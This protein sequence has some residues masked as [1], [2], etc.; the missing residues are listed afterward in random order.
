MRPEIDSKR[1]LID[2]GTTI[3]ILRALIKIKR[4]LPDL[5]IK[6]TK[7]SRFLSKSLFG[8]IKSHLGLVK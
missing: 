3:P 2:D 8:T 6:Y 4:N 7:L 1:K 5:L